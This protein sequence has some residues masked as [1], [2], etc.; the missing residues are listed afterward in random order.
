MTFPTP[1]EELLQGVPPTFL[2][3]RGMWPWAL[4][5]FVEEGAPLFNPD[6]LHLLG[7][8]VLFLWAS[9]DERR[10]GRSVVGT[11][12]LNRKQDARWTQG[13]LE[14]AFREWNE[15][16]AP[17]FV[18]TLSVPFFAKATPLQA[19][20]V[21]EHELYHCGQKVDRYDCPEYNADGSPKYAMRGHDVEEF[22]GVAARYGAYSPALRQ[23][24]DALNAPAMIPVESAE[25][26]MCGC[27]AK[28]G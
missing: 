21:V 3:V 1:P 15:G 25:A 18:V 14:A 19:C 17:D 20:A 26:A 4:A 10:D 28:L 16:S 11:A 6:H 23:L 24:R 22:I 12:E 27:G 2:P 13:R 7:A 9:Y 5:T 8:D